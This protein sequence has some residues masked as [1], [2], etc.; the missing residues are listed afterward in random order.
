MNLQTKR[1]KQRLYHYTTITFCPLTVIT[2]T[3]PPKRG[4]SPKFTNEQ[5][6]EQ[7]RKGKTDVEISYIFNVH[8]NTVMRR[9]WKLN[10]LPNWRIT[11]QTVTNPKE[12]LTQ[13][14]KSEQ[15]FVHAWKHQNRPKVNLSAREQ[16]QRHKESHNLKAQQYRQE[17]LDKFRQYGRNDYAKHEGRESYENYL[18]RYKRALRN[19]IKPRTILTPDQR[20]AKLREKWSYRQYLRQYKKFLSKRTRTP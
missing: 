3:T 15:K 8:D 9:R 14:R 10:L 18:S 20:R 17:N 12:H 1:Y 13:V 19:D 5:F 4:P 7:Y 16:H 11:K 6:L 2:L